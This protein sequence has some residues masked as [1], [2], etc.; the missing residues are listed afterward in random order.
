MRKRSPLN[1]ASQG[2]AS[3]KGPACQCKRRET[4]TIFPLGRSPGGGH[5]NPLQY[6]C[7]KNSMARGVWQATVLRVA[8]SRTAHTTILGGNIVSEPV[9]FL[10]PWLKAAWLFPPGV[11]VQFVWA[12]IGTPFSKNGLLLVRT[13]SLL[14]CLVGLFATPRSIACQ[15]SLSMEFFRQEYWSG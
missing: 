2:G 8:K 10:F 3:G 12:G 14:P 4:D 13:R 5:G 6:S 7:L 9:N 1:V 11:E 15:A